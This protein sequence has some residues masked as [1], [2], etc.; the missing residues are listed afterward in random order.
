MTN[1]KIDLIDERTRRNIDS[2]D[3]N[4]GLYFGN[5]QGFGYFM[6]VR[7]GNFIE[8]NILIKGMWEPVLAEIISSFLKKGEAVIDVGANIGASTIP[9]A[10]KYIDCH[11]YLF[12]PHATIFGD[13]T[14]NIKNN[15]LTNCTATCA[16]VSNSNSEIAF[17]AQNSSNKNMGLSSTR[18]NDD[19]GDYEEVKTKSIRIDDFFLNSKMRVSVLKIDTQ[20]S[21]FE[22]LLSAALTIEKWRP[23]VVFE[24]ESEYFKSEIERREGANRLLSFFHR[25]NY[26]MYAIQNTSKYYPLVS[27]E[28]YFNGDIVA[29]PC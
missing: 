25:F 26:K 20:G 13:L 14:E 2:I 27:L 18:L 3:V 29:V 16:A 4:E 15:C 28:K 7:L 12:E 24:F 11:F 8:S 10:K 19:I 5:F 6:K 1:Q 22:V 9:L 23:L 21:E 17:Y